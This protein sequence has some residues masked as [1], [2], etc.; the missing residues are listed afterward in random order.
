[1]HFHVP[2]TSDSIEQLTTILCDP[3][4]VFMIARPYYS[5][6]AHPAPTSGRR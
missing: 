6:S 2:D 4:D 1:M 3:G 5:Q